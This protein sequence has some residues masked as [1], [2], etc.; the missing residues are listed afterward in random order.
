[1]VESIS[2]YT[3]HY[4]PVPMLPAANQYRPGTGTYRHV[5]G[6]SLNNNYRILVHMISLALHM[7][8]RMNIISLEKDV[9]SFSCVL[10]NSDVILEM[11]RVGKGTFRDAGFRAASDRNFIIS[12]P[13]SSKKCFRKL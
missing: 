10:P 5:Y 1:M 2:L 11:S 4:V 13:T 6:V 8:N 9:C 12:L 7:S 3:C